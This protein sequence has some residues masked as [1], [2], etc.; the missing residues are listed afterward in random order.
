MLEA[1][2]LEFIETWFG[3]PKCVP[4]NLTK[5]YQLLLHTITMN[6]T[7]PFYLALRSGY[8]G[9]LIEEAASRGFIEISLV[10]KNLSEQ[11]R[12]SIKEIIGKTPQQMFV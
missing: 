2:G 10:P 8:T 1:K 4:P 7:L 12:T 11:V 5:L 9:K 3:E 6:G